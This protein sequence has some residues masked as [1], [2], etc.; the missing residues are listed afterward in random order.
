MFRET[1]QGHLC[2]WGNAYAEIQRDNGNRIV[3]LWPRA[4]HKTHPVRHPD[5]GQ[6]FY[7]TTDGM[8]DGKQRAIAADDMLHIPGLSMDGMLGLSPIQQARQ[9]MGLAIATEKFG[10]QFFGNGSR[11]GGILTH[12]AKLSQL[13]SDNLRRI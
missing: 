6:L 8:Q 12:P 2:L 7:V 11:P 10:A 9:A 13:A 1:L 5:S 3:A 4:P